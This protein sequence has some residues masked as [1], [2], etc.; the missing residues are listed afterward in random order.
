MKIF[1][2]FFT[3]FICIGVCTPNTQQRP[4][5]MGKLLTALNQPDTTDEAA[6]TILDLAAKDPSVRPSLAQKLPLMIQKSATDSVWVNAVRLSGE[7]RLSE[8]VPALTKALSHCSV[9]KGTVTLAEYMRLD[10][11]LVG[12]ALAQIGDPSIPSLT[13]ILRTGSKSQRHRATL[14]LLKM[15]SSLSEKTLKDHLFHEG[16]PDIRALIENRSPL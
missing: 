3:L 4:T 8:A 5:D 10:T 6:K 11:D 12:N 13:E 14:I 7:L 9:S 16:D 15:N 1:S 2:L